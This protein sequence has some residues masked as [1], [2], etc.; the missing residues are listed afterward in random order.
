MKITN[1]AFALYAFP[2]CLLQIHVESGKLNYWAS[3]GPG[4]RTPSL[5]LFSLLTLPNLAL[6]NVT[7]SSWV[8][9]FLMPLLCA[10][11]I[12]SAIN[13]KS[14]HSK[15]SLH[16]SSSCGWMIATLSLASNFC[17][18]TSTK[19]HVS[20]HF[21]SHSLI[22][23]YLLLLPWNHFDFVT[24]LKLH[25]PRSVVAKGLLMELSLFKI[26]VPK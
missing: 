16:F 19:K 3:Q 23:W 1:R 2:S 13:C 20:T 24:F 9:C 26:T 14:V 15:F 22:K 4:K 7:S 17:N 12:Q 21:S 10:K 6:L 18:Q 25:L 8:S 5:S 11:R